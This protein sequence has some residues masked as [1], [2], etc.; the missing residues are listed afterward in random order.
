[1]GTTFKNSVLEFINSHLKVVIRQTQML[2]LG[3]RPVFEDSQKLMNF[4]LSALRLKNVRLIR[5][6]YVDIRYKVNTEWEIM[7]YKVLMKKGN[8]F[9]LTRLWE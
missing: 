4:S 1:M 6:P 2:T 3:N 9:Y 5:T 7:T 8:T